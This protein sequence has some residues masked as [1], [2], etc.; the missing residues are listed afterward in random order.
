MVTLFGARH[1]LADQHGAHVGEIGYF[2]NLGT[3]TVQN[4]YVYM[5]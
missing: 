4:L 3:M 1:K 2:I 5:F